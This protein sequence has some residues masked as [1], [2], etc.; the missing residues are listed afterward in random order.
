MGFEECP[1]CSLIFQKVRS[2]VCPRCLDDEDADYDKIRAV[3]G[4]M[5]DLNADQVA[6]EAEV[7]VEVVLR[8]VDE[9]FIANVSLNDSVACGMCGAPAI[10]VAKKLCQGCLEK[11]NAQVAVAQGKV[12]LHDRKQVEVGEVMKNVRKTLDSK[13]GRD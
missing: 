10:S 8:M 5:P 12:K 1:R 7:D 6:T 13:R 4:D 9:G 2:A 11:L 3:I